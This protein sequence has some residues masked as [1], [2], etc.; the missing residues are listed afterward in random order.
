MSQSQFYSFDTHRT[1]NRLVEYGIS[2]KAAEELI[3]TVIMSRD[4]NLSRFVKLEDLAASEKE[5]IERFGKIETEI[6]LIRQEIAFIRKDIA[7]LEEKINGKIDALEERIDA[8]FDNF[9]NKMIAE[10]ARSKNETIR[11]TIGLFLV[12]I[13]AVLVK[14][15][16]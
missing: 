8:K 1:I 10:M 4:F 11:W 12:L 16:M 13:L 5:A 15:Y 14:P 9:E 6:A 2:Q 7:S 3:N